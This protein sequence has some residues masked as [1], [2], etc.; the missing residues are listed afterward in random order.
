MATTKQPE[1]RPAVEKPGGKG[2]DKATKKAGNRRKGKRALAVVLLVMLATAVLAFTFLVISSLVLHAGGPRWLAAVLG[3]LVVPVLPLTW[4][5][6][7]ERQRKRRTPDKTGALRGIDRFLLRAGLVIGV[8][9]G[10]PLALAWDTT[11]DALG[12]HADWPLGVFSSD[13][14]RRSG[15]SG[16][17]S[18]DDLAELGA[19]GELLAIIPEDADAIVLRRGVFGDAKTNQMTT[20][21]L[22]MFAPPTSMPSGQAGGGHTRDDRVS[23]LWAVHDEGFIMPLPGLTGDMMKDSWGKENWKPEKHHGRTI[24]R[25]PEDNGEGLAVVI[26]DDMVVMVSGE[27]EKQLIAR[28]GERRIAPEIADALSRLPD[29]PY[30]GLIVTSNETLGGPLL[31]NGCMALTGDDKELVVRVSLHATA[32]AKA[33]ALEKHVRDKHAEQLQTMKGQEGDLYRQFTKDIKFTVDG[34]LVRIESRVA[35]SD[36]FWAILKGSLNTGP[37]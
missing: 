12:A 33:P 29:Q 3:A 10:A 18:A 13:G 26:D 25:A 36:V 11:T 9:V 8:A 7:R 19:T 37:R 27:W 6:V 31:R 5:L 28:L 2:G 17:L 20:S 23:V 14:D 21:M 32:A 16:G 22:T 34:D 1:P 30:I 24:W 15:A 4:H 35:V